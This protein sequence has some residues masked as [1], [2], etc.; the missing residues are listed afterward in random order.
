[1]SRPS[2]KTLMSVATSG[3][4]LVAAGAVQAQGVPPEHYT[5]DPRGV[6]LVMGQLVYTTEEVAI[7]QPGAGGLEHART[8]VGTSWGGFWLSP[9]NGSIGVSIPESIVVLDGRSEIFL[10]SGPNNALTFT[11]K[12]DTGSRLVQTS[13]NVYRYTRSDGTVVVFEDAYSGVRMLSRDRPNGEKISYNYLYNDFCAEWDWNTGTSC[14]R[15][16]MAIRIASITNNHGYQ[17]RYEYASADPENDL[18]GFH[19]LRSVV[20]FNMAVDYCDPL[21][22]NCSFSRTWPRIS[23]APDGY[24][25]ALATDQ[26]GRT[27]TYL[28]GA[29][30]VNG[31]VQPGASAPDFTLTWDGSGRVA[32]LTDA[33]GAWAYTYTDAG[34]IRTTTSTGPLGQSTVIAT[35]LSAG[36][37]SS[38]TQASGETFSYQYD[39]QYRLSRITRPGGAYTQYTYDTRGNIT[40]TR[41]VARAGSGMADIVTSATYPANCSVPVTC[42]QPLTTTD[43]RG[44]VA[45]YTWDPVHGGPLT[46]TAPAPAS[47]AARPQTRYY[48]APQ[49]AYYRNSSG[50]MAPAPSAVTLPT[51]VNACATGTS[52]AG[53]DA[54]VRTTISY[55]GAGVANN[56][57]PVAI[58]RGSGANP[59]SGVS[60]VTY[61]ANGDI[62][63]ID[64]PVS[65]SAD[66]M[67]YRYDAARQVVGVIGP[68]PDGTGPGAHRAQRL[69]YNPRGQVT[70]AEVGNTAGYSDASFAA[71]NPVLRSETTYDAYGRPVVTREQ[72][73]G[74]ITVV[75]SQV[76]YDAAGRPDCT[77]V[78]M[79]PATFGSLPAS[80]CTPTTPGSDGPD[81]ISRTTYDTASRPVTTT[82]ALGQ[83]EAITETVSYTANG[84]VATMTDGN[85]NVS[86]R[87]Y[88]GHDRPTRLRYPHASGGGT[89]TTDYHEV[90]YDPAGNVASSRNRAGQLTTIA[91]DNLN[92]PTLVDAPSGTMDIATTYDNLGRVLTTSGNGQTLTRTW[93]PLSNMTSEAGP[94]GTMSY[95]HDQARRMTRITW[96]DGFHAQYD[97]DVYGA[98]TAIRENSATSG[99]G[100][101]AIYGYGD[102]GQLTGISRGN[103]VTT[104]YGYDAA[105]RMI[106]LAHNMAGG[107]YDVTFS[108]GWNAAGQIKERTTWSPGYLY[109]PV[110]GGMTYT[111]NGSNQVTSIAGTAITYDANQNIASGLGK[112]FAYDAAGRLISTATS[113]YTYDP[114]GR[115]YGGS[116]SGT[117]LS[118]SGAQLSGE[119]NA[120]GTMLVRHIPGPGLDQ[121]I[122]S[123]YGAGLATRQWL[124][125]DERRSVINISDA[126]GATLNINRYDEYGVPAPG[127]SDRFQYTGQ[128]LIEP[129]LYN[130]RNRAYAP[131]FGRFLQTD[132]IGYG[133]GMNVYG[134]VGGGPG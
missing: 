96:P 122:V 115:M 39:S 11:P 117:Y 57:L 68:D 37:P 124:V 34:G 25:N 83:A 70:V 38:V 82:S 86:I 65:G 125:Q 17:L 77:A 23:Y 21:A 52:C 62:E 98:V 72:T 20:G 46:V 54:E 2:L 4:A 43:A 126:S 100:L 10:T 95:Q 35:P 103:G 134:Y 101:L 6:D 1:M 85:G 133:D 15:R 84:Q 48:Y 81:R 12:S 114:A 99:P 45:D 128:A 129:G 118:Y 106:S 24:G 41:E 89:S 121:P 22:M 58:S 44:H 56:L 74:A 105:R 113:S 55:A 87:E 130:Y 19:D 97:R 64:G 88:D 40:Q 92:R 79:N 112:N 110:T 120:S 123:S 116:S 3:I 13:R 131:Q 5:L 119:H 132:P 27:T 8:Y 33:T 60:Q 42:N 28:Q 107:A 29:H 127:N 71:F 73:G 75:A 7:G 90:G 69:T 93:D 50:M 67:R 31:V 78:R 66:T 49:T 76:S 94:L 53:T 91:Y 109:A 32:S 51:Q 80:A 14:M 47:G 9:E 59:W 18:N 63:S 102:V 104:S 111:N 61:T 26:S 36:R 108:Y 30:G 16:D